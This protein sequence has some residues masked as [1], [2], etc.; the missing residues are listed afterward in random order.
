MTEAE[1]GLWLRYSKMF[2]LPHRSATYQAASIAR[3]VAVTMGG[4]KSKELD[5]FIVKPAAK[6][7]GQALDAESG[8]QLLGALGSAR[9]YRLGQKK[10]KPN[11]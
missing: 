5:D 8:G 4:S 2:F 10:R 7:D 11:G 9:V 3:L 1:F 6:E